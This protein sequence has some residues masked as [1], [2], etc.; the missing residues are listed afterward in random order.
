[1]VLGAALSCALVT[2]AAA[3]VQFSAY[4]GANFTH[5]SDVTLARPGGTNA[6]FSNVPW[7]GNSFKMP[8]YWGLRFTYWLESI[9]NLG[10]GVDYT[11]AKVY[12]KLGNTVPASGTVGG[13][14][15]GPNVL[16]RNV[17]QRLEFTDGLNLVTAHAFYR[18]P[19]GGR[20]TPYL[21]VGVGAA[22]PHVEVTMAGYPITFQYELTGIA[23]RLYGGVDVAITNGWSLFG[24]YQFSYAQVRNASLTGGGTLSTDLLSH[25]F[26]LGVSYAFKPF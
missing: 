14:P 19:M 23:A 4:L 20:L 26:N 1:M 17:F 5:S 6:K 7:D 9:P 3:E 10:F 25:H 2:P 13:V 8:P 21:G 12:A 16:L 24:E 22:I 15:I 11:H 18:Y